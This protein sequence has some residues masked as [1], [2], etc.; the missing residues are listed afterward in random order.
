MLYFVHLLKLLVCSVPFGGGWGGGGM[1]E[2]GEGSDD[3]ESE[4]SNL[5]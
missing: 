2:E 4:Q 3:P 1:G 5:M